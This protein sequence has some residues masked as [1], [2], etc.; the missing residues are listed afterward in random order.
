[1]TRLPSRIVFAAAL[2]AFL[3]DMALLSAVQKG[4]DS[5]SCLNVVVDGQQIHADLAKPIPVTATGQIRAAFVRMGQEMSFSADDK[6]RSQG[7]RLVKTL[8]EGGSYQV[9]R[10]CYVLMDYCAP[11]CTGQ[12]CATTRVPGIK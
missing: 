1:M 4:P 6:E 3:P 12:G 10:V 11:N 8:I 5:I 9:G 2:L 7:A